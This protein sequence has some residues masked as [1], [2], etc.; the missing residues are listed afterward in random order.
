M[1]SLMVTLP[2]ENNASTQVIGGSRTM[3][4]GEDV[5]LSCRLIETTED[6]EQ[7]TWQKSTWEEKQNHNFMLIYPNGVTNFI[8]L[9]GL[10]GR[11]QFIGNTSENL[12]SIRITAV[13]LLD[14]GTFTCIFSIFPSGAY[15]TEIS[16]TVLVPPV[17]SVTVDVPPVIG[18][19]EVVLATCVAA[20]AKPQAE[21]KWKTGA[22]GSLLRTVTNFTQHA[23]GTATVLSHLL[24]VPTRAA[25]QQQVQCVVNQSALATE[26]SYNYTINIHCKCLL[27]PLSYTIDRHY[28]HCKYILLLLSYT[29]D[30]HCKYILLPLS[31]T[32]DRHC[33]YILLPLSYTIDRHCK[34]I[35]LPLSYTIDRHCKY[36]LL[37]LSYTI[38]RHCKYILLLLS[39]TIDRHCKYILLPLSYNR[40]CKYILLPLSYTIDRHCKYIILLLSYTID[41]HCKYILLPLSYTIDRHCK[42]IL[43][44]LSYTID[45]HCK[46][47]LLPLS[48]TIDRHCKSIL[49]P[50][51][52][53][54]DRHCKYILLPLS[55]T[56]DRHC[57][58]ILL[59][60]SYT[61]DRHC[62][63]ILLPLSYTIDRH[64][65]PQSVNI[66]LSE[67]SQATVLL[68]LADVNPQP[69]YTWSSSEL[70]GL[71]VC[72]ASNPY[73]RATGSLFVHTSSETSAACWVLLIVI[74]CLIVTAAALT[75]SVSS[76]RRRHDKVEEGEGDSLAATVQT[77]NE[78]EEEEEV[79]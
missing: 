75:E 54:I 23:N 74:L 67:A 44:P 57:K 39:Y 4:Q 7:I 43:L 26:S 52:Y 69:N 13:R 50:L 33:K 66:T 72:E 9:N 48:Y 24:G 60:L 34:Y 12:G 47:I 3:V 51:S 45:R 53:T 31:Y 28:R 32:I 62:K 59:P 71:Y 10:K 27:L 1:P 58:Y 65:P 77:R 21:V 61:I 14:E 5:D 2:E 76:L 15:S 73:G 42:Y 56:I 30:R 78:P 70:N 22:F 38:D 20:V 41:R 19:N 6:L 36:I 37:P 35:L 18:E 79:S 68:C 25:N 49:L 11:V 17:V 8:A 63:Y 55:Y 16:L 64:Y 29:I 40:H 46:Y